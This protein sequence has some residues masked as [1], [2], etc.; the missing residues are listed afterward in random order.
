MAGFT[1]AMEQ[2]ILDEVFGGTAYAAEAS[3]QVGLLTTNPSDDSGTGLVETS[4]TGYSRQT[5]TNNTTNFP[6][7]TGGDPTV[8]SNGTAISFGQ[9]TDAGDVTIVG[10]GIWEAD[11]TTLMFTGSVTPN[12]TVSQNDTPEFAIGDLDLKLGDPGDSY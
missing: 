1:D 3:V 7:A 10:F 9:K 2:A 4:Y 6:A 5:L 8:K 12:A 11:G